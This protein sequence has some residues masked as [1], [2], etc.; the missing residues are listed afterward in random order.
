MM[1]GFCFPEDPLGHIR[2]HPSRSGNL[3][4]DVFCWTSEWTIPA[5]L[6]LLQPG[7]SVLGGGEGRC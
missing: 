3:S 5:A 7:R 2:S 1:G 6:I 4:G